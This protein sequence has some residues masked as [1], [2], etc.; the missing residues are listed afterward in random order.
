MT[1]LVVT[2][3]STERTQRESFDDLVTR[4]RPELLA[5]CRRRVGRDRAEE[6]VSDVLLA[7]AQAERSGTQLSAGWLIGVARNKVVDEWR[8]DERRARLIERMRSECMLL[9]SNDGPETALLGDVARALGRLSAHHRS[10]LVRH[11]VH[12]IPLGELAADAGLSYPAAESAIAR[13]R[14][15]FRRHYLDDPASTQR[16]R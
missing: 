9:A 6:I 13:A 8:R 3:Q 1:A 14:R 16:S 4:M 5:F 12:G 2:E 7:A 11:Y 15:A 10:L